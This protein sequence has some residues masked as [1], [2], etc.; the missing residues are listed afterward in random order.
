VTVRKTTN[1]TAGEAGNNIAAAARCCDEQR[2]V[3]VLFSSP[4]LFSKRI[5]GEK[6]QKGGKTPEFQ[7]SL[8]G[9]TAAHPPKQLV[10]RSSQHHQPPNPHHQADFPLCERSRKIWFIAPPPHPSPPHPTVDSH[11][12]RGRSGKAQQAAGFGVFVLSD[13]DARPV[14]C[15]WGGIL[16]LV[17]I[18]PFPSFRV[19]T[20]DDTLPLHSGRQFR[21]ARSGCS[22]H[23]HISPNP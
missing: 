4:L 22:H 13:C 17:L 14:I 10:H 19:R 3:F 1:R 11:L 15:V 6:S 16:S 7:F 8:A 5:P 20:A 21:P 2:T 23:A 12:Q 18:H 9:R